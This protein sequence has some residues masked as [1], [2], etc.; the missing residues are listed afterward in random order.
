M[1][2]D[3]V[4]TSGAVVGRTTMDSWGR[5][6]LHMQRGARQPHEC[7]VV[8]P[9]TAPDGKTWSIPTPFDIFN[10]IVKEMESCQDYEL[11]MV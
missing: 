7:V 2:I 11:H 6:S 4:F 1:E 5:P 9:T 3:H 10:V 8:C